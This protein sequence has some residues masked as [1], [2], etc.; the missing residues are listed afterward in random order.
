MMSVMV[1]MKVDPL[2]CSKIYMSSLGS[3]GSRV[4]PNGIFQLLYLVNQTYMC[5]RNFN[6][7]I[8]RIVL[9]PKSR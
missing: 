3:L 6:V 2:I 8:G 7:V 5:S 4:V 1:Y 9:L